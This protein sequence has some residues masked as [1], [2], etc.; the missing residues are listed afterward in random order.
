MMTVGD[1]I[2][3]RMSKLGDVAALCTIIMLFSVLSLLA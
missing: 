1:G 2:L 3:E